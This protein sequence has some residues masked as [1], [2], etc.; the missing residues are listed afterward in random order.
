[1]ESACKSNPWAGRRP[2]AS[3]GDAARAA[4][5]PRRPRGSERRGGPLDLPGGPPSVVVNPDSGLRPLPR[6]VRIGRV[7]G[8]FLASGAPR[9]ARRPAPPRLRM[10]RSPKRAHVPCAGGAVR[11]RREEAAG[12]GHF[13]PTT[14]TGN[15]GMP[16]RP[17]L[18]LDDFRRR[19]SLRRPEK[20]S[21]PQDW[22]R[23]LVPA[24]GL[25]VLDRAPAQA[26][27]LGTPP[28]SRTEPGA[29]CYLWVIDMNGIPYIREAPISSIA[30]K[31][32]KHT[33]ITGGGPAYLG[34]ELW[35]ESDSRLWVSGGSGR[36]SPIDGV[37]LDCA[38]QV[39]RDFRYDVTSLGWDEG[40]GKAKRYREQAA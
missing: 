34:G 35:F 26:V 21:P 5:S 39:F 20:K 12:R 10:A 27:S 13:P 6:D 19:Y 17:R 37:Q 15:A 16:N 24:D 2:L 22:N 29:N 11:A 25:R 14:G 40:I 33:N 38:V 31:K 30:G 1:M 32:P 18:P 7:M 28:P 3:Q 9:R 4:F 23:Q 8:D 36:Y